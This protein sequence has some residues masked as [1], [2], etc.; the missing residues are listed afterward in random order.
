M[1]RRKK[2][3]PVNG[4]LVI[5]KPQGV[6]S[7]QMVGKAR[8]ALRAQKAGH[9]GTLDSLPT[10]VLAIAFGE[11]TK[12]VPFAMDCDKDYRFT[13]RWGEATDSDDSEGAVIARSDKRPTRAAIEAALPDFTGEIMQIPP[14][15]SAIKVEGER[16]YAIM[17]EGDDVVLESRPISV[18]ALALVDMPDADTAVFEMTCGKGGYVRAVARDLG[19]AL[20]CYG[21]VIALRR[22]RVGAFEAEDG[23]G[24]E[25]LE[26]MRD[27]PQAQARLL[28]VEAGLSDLPSMA[29]TAAHKAMLEQG[30]AIPATGALAYGDAAWAAFQGAPVAVGVVKGGMFQPTRVILLDAPD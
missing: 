11:A 23:V 15:Y 4:W 2:G 17:R 9:A 8:W 7:T 27:D 19:L 10:G 22:M 29:I 13:V 18:Y 5:D 14:K 3:D 24:V 21:H 12:T 20:G 28:P 30:R 6:T 26:A 16:A 25:A 1:A